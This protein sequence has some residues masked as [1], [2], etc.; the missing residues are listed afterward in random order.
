MKIDALGA[1]WAPR[2]LSVLRIM[3]GLLLLQHGTGKLLKFPVGVVPANF[4]LMS[5]PGYAGIIELVCGILLVIGVF[6]RPQPS[7]PRA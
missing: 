1:A 7:S 3:S 5:M 4:N 6:S 2:L